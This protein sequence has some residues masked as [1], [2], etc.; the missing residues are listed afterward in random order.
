VVKGFLIGAAAGAMAVYFFDP[1]SGEDR[2]GRAM[3]LWDENKD[4]VLKTSRMVTE[5][6]KSGSEQLA[7]VA[8]KARGEVVAQK[9]SET[10]SADDSTPP[11]EVGTA[12][13]GK[14]PPNE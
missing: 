8:T 10:P 2:R 6:V 14:H 5:Q 12:D 3:S 4:Q 11:A 9:A 1:D 7:A 13:S